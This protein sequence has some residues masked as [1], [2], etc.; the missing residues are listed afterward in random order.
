MQNIDYASHSVYRAIP[1]SKRNVKDGFEDIADPDKNS[2]SPNGWNEN[3]FK[4]INGTVGNNV[5]AFDGDGAV[6][7]GSGLNFIHQW[8]ENQTPASSENSKAALGK[9][10]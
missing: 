8:S 5:L 2:A 3:N 10:I 7:G 9:K 4:N 6:G 1:I